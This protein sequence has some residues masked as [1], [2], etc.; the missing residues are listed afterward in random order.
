MNKWMYKAFF[1]MIL[2][3]FVPELIIGQN[4]DEWIRPGEDHPNPIWGHVEGIRVGIAPSP[5]PRGLIRIFTPYLGLEEDK[6]FNFIAFEPIP[7]GETER[8]FSELEM[9]SL[10]KTRGKRFWSSND[11]ICACPPSLD[12]HAGGV[13]ENIKGIETLTVYIFS[14]PFENGANVYTRI[15]FFKDRP[16]E[17]ELSTY[18]CELSVNLENFIL[19]ATMGNYAR[20]RN[21][22][23]LENVKSSLILWPDYKDVHFTMHDET[24]VI[25]MIK[26]GKSGVY[27]I[28]EP[29]EENLQSV[30]YAPGTQENWIY[31]GNHATQYWYSPL[32]DSSLKGLVNGRYTYWGSKAPIPGGISFENFEFKSPFKNG[33][34][35]VF[36]VSPLTAEEFIKQIE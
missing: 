1:L 27:F 24:P 29:D 36:G 9:S 2:F 21:L 17:F 35:F 31:Y 14:E 33:E 25:Q 18:K 12:I 5:G 16:Y 19:T 32:P 22:F 3:I 15:R 28:A 8:G 20:L 13:I 10:D 7:E 11:S 34:S 30:D 26:D 23:L 4:N 6:V